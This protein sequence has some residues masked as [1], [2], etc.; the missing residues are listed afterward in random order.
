MYEQGPDGSNDWRTLRRTH[1][2]YNLSEAYLNRRI[3]GLAAG[4]YL[5]APDANGYSIQTLMSKT[6]ME[7]DVGAVCSGSCYTY[8]PEAPS[9]PVVHHDA[10]Y[11]SSFTL[12]R[13]LL[14]GV[15]RWDASQE[16]NEA[17]TTTSSLLYNIYGSVIRS[18]DPLQHAT[19]IHY[20]DSFSNDG[21]GSF[22]APQLTLAYPTLVS[23]PDGFSS[24]AKYSYDLGAVTRQLDAKGAA[25]T[26]VYDAVGRVKQAT[27]TVNGAYTRF[28]YPTSQTIVNKFTTIN[29]LQHEAYAATM[30]DGAGRVR[31][32]AGDFPDPGGTDHYSGQFTLYDTMG[33]AVQATNPTEMTHAWAATGADTGWISTLQTYD[34]K[35]R[36][37][38]TTNPSITSDPTHV[39]TKKAS[40]GGCGCAGG[41]VVTL[42]DEELR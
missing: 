21:V 27:N 22:T 1:T 15:K 20:D 24:S 4:Q 30:L 13:G 34:W 3:I 41:A 40:Y 35:G 8:G 37:L 5:F 26:T 23:D 12:G 18:V 28:V 33:R 6:T 31:A 19:Q 9:D 2:D 17:K 29:D 38:V 36:P 14:S 42:T 7:Y 11:N 16:L 39:T 32:A 10:T 25:Q